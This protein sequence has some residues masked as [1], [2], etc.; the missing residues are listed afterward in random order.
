[1]FSLGDLTRSSHQ[2]LQFDTKMKS[3]GW[4]LIARGSIERFCEHFAIQKTILPYSMQGFEISKHFAIQKTILPYAMQG[5]E[6]SKHFAIQ[7]TIAPYSMQGFEISKHFA[8]QNTIVPYS[9][10]EFGLQKHFLVW[11]FQTPSSA[12]E[13][14]LK[15]TFWVD[16]WSHE[17]RL[18]GSVSTNFYRD[19][20]SAVD[21]HCSDRGARNLYILKTFN[22][23]PSWSL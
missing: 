1:M 14:N 23:T 7:N 2:N 16:N 5:F 20:P 8:I 11:I 19:A 13:F 22:L 12:G 3:L 9:I 15:F 18:S 10:R 21:I 4:K 17:V 6:I